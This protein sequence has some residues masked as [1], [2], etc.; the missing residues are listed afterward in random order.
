M[1]GISLVSSLRMEYTFAMYEAERFFEFLCGLG[2]EDVYTRNR[3][4]KSTQTERQF[5]WTYFS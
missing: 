1:K 5:F 2:L 4:E 3:E